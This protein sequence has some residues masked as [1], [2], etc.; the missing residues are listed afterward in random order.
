RRG[1]GAKHPVHAADDRIARAGIAAGFRRQ[2]LLRDRFRRHLQRSEPP[3]R[4]GA[5]RPLAW[6]RTSVVSIHAAPAR[7]PTVLTNDRHM[8]SGRSTP[9]TSAMPAA[10]R[11][12][13]PIAVSTATVVTSELPGTPA[14]ANAAAVA[15]TTIVTSC[16]GP[17]GTPYRCARNTA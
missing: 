2:D 12:P 11:G 1:V 3:L 9:A 15:V 17:S 6:P 14:P 5:L 7:L 8:S 16:S 13:R 10:A 4:G